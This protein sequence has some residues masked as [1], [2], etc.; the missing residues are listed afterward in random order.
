MAFLHCVSGNRYRCS[1]YHRSPGSLF[2]I[3][4]V[5]HVIAVDAECTGDRYVMRRH[6]EV[7]SVVLSDLPSREVMAFLHCVSGNRYRCS[8]RNLC[9]GGL[10]SVNCVDYIV[11]LGRSRICRSVGRIRS[12]LCNLRIPAIEGI[13]VF[14]CCC[15]GRICR[16]HDVSRSRAFI[17]FSC[18]L[19]N[20]PIFIHEGYFILSCFS[21]ECSFFINRDCY[22][23]GCSGLDCH[24]SASPVAKRILRFRSN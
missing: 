14:I 13:S 20:S 2:A 16:L 15:L 22:Q 3:Y 5:D 23:P 11:L 1:V 21:L 8:E 24:L 7:R 18:S 19:Q 6:V 12:Y 4:R 9:P 17:I 10:C